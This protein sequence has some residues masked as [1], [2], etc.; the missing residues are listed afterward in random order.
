MGQHTRNR[1]TTLQVKTAQDGW[2]ND[3]GNLHLRVSNGGKSKKWVLRY[4]RDGKV[5]EI[6][7]GG[8]DQVTLKLARTLRDQHLETLAKGGDPRE[9]KRKQAVVRQGRKTFA[10]AAA[11]LIEKRRNK[12]RTSVNEGR[13]S[14][15]NDWTKSLTV[16]CKPISDRFV[17]DIETDDIERIVRPYWDKG[18]E[19]TA[20]RLLDRVARVFDYAKAK[21]WRKADNPATWALFQTILQA[22][23]PTG[24]K[25][26]HPALDWRRMPAFMA[27]L[28]A[29]EPSMAAMALELMILTGGRSG[30]VRG[31][32]WSEVDFDDATWRV[33][34]ER[35]KRKLP[36]EVALSGDAVALLKRLDTA[37]IGPF[38]F[39][40][41]WN[42]GPIAHQAIWDLV[43]RLTDRQADQPVAASPHGFRSSFR[44]WMA[45]Q[46]TPFEVA[47]S[48]LSH[49]IGSATSQAYNRANLLNLRRP[50]M[51]RWAKFLSGE[52]ASN[53]VPLRRA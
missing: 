45:E 11:E 16:D 30:E 9:E 32:L 31:M 28:R 41:R 43:Q 37:R 5:T 48:V 38:V 50:I 8:A 1:L 29:D 18:R 25:R 47:E 35:M 40:G 3:G 52:D 24:P 15:L 23:G 34:G 21:G 6:G 51:E 42:D 19:T 49:K 22:H 14:S 12:W 27:R 4:Q 44:S 26:H 36:H 7:L 20:R 39:P 2:L 46:Q 17:G 53:V 33:P 10:E 13:T